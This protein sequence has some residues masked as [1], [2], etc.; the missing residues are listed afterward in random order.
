MIPGLIT[1]TSNSVEEFY[2]FQLI[3]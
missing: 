2:F 1:C 3:L